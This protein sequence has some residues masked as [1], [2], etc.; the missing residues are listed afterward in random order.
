MT[1]DQANALGDLTAAGT[2][3]KLSLSE[4][5]D[6]DNDAKASFAANARSITATIAEAIEVNEAEAAEAQAAQEQ[7]AQEALKQQQ[8]A[9]EEKNGK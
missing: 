1:V 5:I 2:S 7:A 3:T 6:K 4:S 9:Q 8:E